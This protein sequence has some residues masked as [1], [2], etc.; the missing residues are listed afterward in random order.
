MS[1]RRTHRG[2]PDIWPGFVDALSTLL[3]VI[4]FLLMVFVLAQFFMNQAIS[5]RD[6]ALDKLHH[7]VAE[8]AQMLSLERK[9]NDELRGNLAQIS[10]ELQASSAKL[11]KLEGLSDETVKLNADVAALQALKAELEARVKTLDA[12]VGEKDSALA[13]ER[14]LSEEARAQAALLNQQLTVL[15]SE[16]ARLNAAL[17]ASEKVNADQK[18]QI[19]NLGQRL[20]QALATKVAEL[21]K[22]RSEFFGRLREVLGNR[23]DVR[24]QGDRFVFQS[25]I[26]FAQGSADLGENGKRQLDRLARTLIDISKKIPDDIDWILRV[27]GHTDRVPIANDQFRSNWELSSAR[28]IAVVRYLIGTGLPAGR[29]VA[30]GFGEFQ[31]I[32]PGNSPAALA[33]NRRIEFK[34]TQR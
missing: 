22:Y 8:M 13:S 12:A 1:V 16:L 34:L 31:P 32:D 29:L 28:A 30:A 18:A 4:L 2:S 25:E 5:G 6:A 19:A 10:A 27:D 11:E 15:R 3:I 7:Q 26:L 24:I 20:N 21:A 23:A 9:S 33:R 17:E 14:K